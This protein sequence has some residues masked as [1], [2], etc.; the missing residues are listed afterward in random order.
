MAR[1]SLFTHALVA[2]TLLAGTAAV[3]AEQR[4]QTFTLRSQ[5][6]AGAIDQIK[7]TLEVSGEL[8]VVE[9]GKPQQLKTAGQANLNRHERL[10]TDPSAGGGAV[11]SIHSYE[12]ASA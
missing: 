5:L 6:A 3:S 4:S 9:E 11:R 10:L 1:S 8:V 12:I 7:S 2:A